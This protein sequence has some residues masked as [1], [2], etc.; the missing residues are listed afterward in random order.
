[1][2]FKEDA[3]W[4]LSSSFWYLKM[5]IEVEVMTLFNFIVDHGG[6]N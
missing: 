1:M 5:E 2:C 6:E 4:F 3:T